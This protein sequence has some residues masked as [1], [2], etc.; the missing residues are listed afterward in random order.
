MLHWRHMDIRGF[1]GVYIFGVATHPAHRGEGLAS[2]LISDLLEGL[3]RF[4]FAALVSETLSLAGFYERFG[5]S[6][7]GCLPDDG[8]AVLVKCLRGAALCE[9]AYTE[10]ARKIKR[11]EEA[12][13]E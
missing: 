12:S 8:R 6:R 1:K 7:R 13:E 5:F 9:E 2:R 4:D 10:L 3:D 11:F